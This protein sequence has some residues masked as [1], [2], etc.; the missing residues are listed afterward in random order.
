MEHLSSLDMF[1]LPNASP[2]IP[3]S[4]KMLY[5]QHFERFTSDFSLDG[6]FKSTKEKKMFG[7][8]KT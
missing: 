6:L 4:A 2:N 8:F 1:H 7:E 5:K 3:F